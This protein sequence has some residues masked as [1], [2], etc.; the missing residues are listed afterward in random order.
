[1]YLEVGG[2]GVL[3]TCDKS[4]IESLYNL[5]ACKIQS[6]SRVSQMRIADNLS[7]ATKGSN[8]NRDC[9]VCFKWHGGDVRHVD[10]GVKLQAG[11]IPK[12]ESGKLLLNSTGQ[13]VVWDRNALPPTVNPDFRTYRT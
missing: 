5:D 8:S 3:L 6:S 9:D 13:S 12:E 11:S 10:E 1:M 7:P 4:L 2:E